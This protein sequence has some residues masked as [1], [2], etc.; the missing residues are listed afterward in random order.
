[1]RAVEDNYLALGWH[2][3]FYAPEKI[4]R[5]FFGGGNF[6]TDDPGSLRVHGTQNVGDSATF[7]GGIQTLQADEEGP[8]AFCNRLFWSW[9]MDSLHFLSL[10]LTD[11]SDLYPAVKSGSILFN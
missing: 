2:L 6:K 5:R 10:L 8:F 3:L 4:M 9:R 7:T 1:M 11:F